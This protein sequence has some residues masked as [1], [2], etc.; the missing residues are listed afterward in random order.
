MK[1]LIY[2]L[3]VVAAG[4]VVYNITFLDFNN[5]FA[6]DSATALI[7]VLACLIVILLMAILLV[8]RSIAKK[9]EK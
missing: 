1:I 3:M 9:A 5:L 2:V 7:G 4:L 8:S 6:G